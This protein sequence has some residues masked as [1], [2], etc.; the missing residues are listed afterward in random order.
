MLSRLKKYESTDKHKAFDDEE[1]WTL[2]VV[3]GFI[4][5]ENGALIDLAEALTGT[6][7]ELVNE[8]WLEMKPLPPRKGVSGKSERNS[9]ID[10]LIGDV[11]KRGKTKAGVKYKAESSEEDGWVCFVEAKWLSDI[12]IKTTHDWE[13]N[14]LARVVETALTFQGDGQWPS[15]VHVTLLTP[16][17]FETSRESSASRLYAYKW[18]EY[19]NDNGSIKSDAILADIRQSHVDSRTATKGWTYPKLEER[20]NCLSMRW[21]TYE[22]LLKAMP[23][24]EFKTALCEF[25]KHGTRLLQSCEVA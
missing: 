16:A 6:K 5:A 4:A 14:Q 2:L 18:R 24:S 15:R 13:R 9:Q 25:A 7:P 22:Q 8:A 11:S 23:A 10:L 3:Y 12:A 21:V 20:I 1:V 17:R 19:V